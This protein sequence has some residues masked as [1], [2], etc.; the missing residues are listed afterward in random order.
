MFWDWPRQQANPNT[1]VTM[2]AA[3][4]IATILSSSACTVV[5]SDFGQSFPSAGISTLAADVDQGDIEIQG[6]PS[7]SAFVV[8]GR[9]FGYSMS[10]DNAERNQ[11]ANTWDV[12]RDGDLLTM[13]GRSEYM[14]AGVDF[15][16]RGPSQVH[17]SLTTESG[18]INI[19]DLQGIH[20]LEATGVSAENLVGSTTIIAGSGGV[21]ATLIPAHSDTIYIESRD[22]VVLR[23]PWGGDYNLQIWGDPEYTITVHDLGFSS[24]A[25][26]PAYFAGLRGRGTTSVDIVVTGG[27]VTVIDTW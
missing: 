12:S 4:I 26:A 17:T 27:N 15:E 16:V 18:R 14:G 9:T 19:S 6:L 2:R 21:N 20:Y 11:D 22:D 10:S 25:E 1:E 5:E 3:F 7:S 23:L 8:E 13:W 24:V